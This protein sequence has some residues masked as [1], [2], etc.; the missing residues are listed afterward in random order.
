M[1]KGNI[2]LNGYIDVPQ[3]MIAQAIPL[4]ETHIELTRAEAGCISFDVTPSA[5]VPARFDVAEVFADQAAFD[6]HQARSKASLWGVF[7]QAMPRSY[8]I[9]VRE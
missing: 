8:E 9:T 1:S 6:L 3:D 7:T 4:L 2:Q 5:L